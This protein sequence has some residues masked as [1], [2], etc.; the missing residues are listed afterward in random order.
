MA[1]SSSSTQIP[2]TFAH[3]CRLTKLLGELLPM[4][5]SLRPNHAEN[6]K[7]IRRTECALD[8]WVDVLP[9]RLNP[10]KDFADQFP[11]V[12]GASSL[13]FCFLSLQLVLNRLA[14]KVRSLS[15]LSLSKG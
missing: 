9:D 1:A 15:R 4:I 10:T 7:Q 12:P 11:N 6:W 3:L 2:E 13:W 8:D 14:F 5:Y